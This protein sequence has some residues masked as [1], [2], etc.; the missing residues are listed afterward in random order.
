MLVRS[1]SSV[2]L[3]LPGR[4]RSSRELERGTGHGTGE[5][6]LADASGYGLAA[7][8]PAQEQEGPVGI[9]RQW[10][11]RARPPPSQTPKAPA[12]ELAQPHTAQP[13]TPSS[14]R[15]PLRLLAP[16]PT[17]PGRGA[18]RPA[19]APAAARPPL[20][21]PPPLPPPPRPPSSPC[22]PGRTARPPAAPPRQA[23]AAPRGRSGRSRCRCGGPAGS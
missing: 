8:G 5:S 2:V 19:P 11:P 20:P 7:A 15:A 22:P 17:R 12:A 6:G 4:P 21:L 13:L 9:G 16:A 3:P 18:R 10:P 23:R 1:R 14:A